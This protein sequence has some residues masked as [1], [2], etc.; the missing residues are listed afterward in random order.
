M[1]I[2]SPLGPDATLGARGTEYEIDAR[3]VWQEVKVTLAHLSDRQPVFEDDELRAYATVGDGSVSLQVIPIEPERSRIVVNAR[4]F[5]VESPSL[6]QTV[7]AGID[8]QI[9]DN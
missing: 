9:R 7:I 1:G 8:R 6:T 5:G 2:D 4:E 3:S